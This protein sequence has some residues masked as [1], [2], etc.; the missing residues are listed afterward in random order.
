MSALQLSVFRIPVYDEKRQEAA[1]EIGRRPFSFGW[2]MKPPGVL[3][4][5]VSEETMPAPDTQRLVQL[6]NSILSEVVDSKDRPAQLLEELRLRAV[7][8]AS[9][10]SDEFRQFGEASAVG[11][12]TFTPEFQD[13]LR[14]MLVIGYRLRSVELD[15]SVLEGQNGFDLH[16]VELESSALEGQ[17]GFDLHLVELDSSVLEG[18]SGYHTPLEF[19]KLLAE[20]LPYEPD[21]QTGPDTCPGN[22][23]SATSSQLLSLESA[24]TGYRSVYQGLRLSV[25]A[26][27]IRGRISLWWRCFSTLSLKVIRTDT[28][29]EKIY[30]AYQNRHPHRTEPKYPYL[31]A[32][33]SLSNGSTSPQGR[34]LANL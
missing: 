27:H 16:P 5:V 14:F 31:S 7:W 6:L 19:S 11:L 4:Q 8:E 24:R 29:L 2:S 23:H 33:D 18:Q 25:M 9:E 17:S 1:C 12:D 20:G 34:G 26:H 13:A 28:F 15:S 32:P 3:N 22:Y 21:R 10:H 30:C